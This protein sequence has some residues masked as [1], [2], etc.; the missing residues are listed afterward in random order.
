MDLKRLFL[1]GV[2]LFAYAFTFL[3]ALA[4]TFVL[5]PVVKNFAIRIG[6][7]DKPDARKVH[8][9]LVPRLG[10]LAIYAGFMVSAITTIGFTY[11]MVGIMAGATF[12]IIVG[13]ADDV[14]S[15]RPKVKLLGQIIAAAIPVVIFNINIDWINVPW[16]GIVYLPAVISIPL[17]IFWIIGFINTVNL[18]DGLDGLAAGIATIASIAIALL[19]FQMGQWTAAAAMVA[20]TGACLAFLQYNFNPAKIFMG[21]TGSMFLGYIIAAVSVMGSMKTAAAAVLIVPLVALAVPITDTLLA[22]VRRKSSGVPIF[23]PD[24]NHLHH[25]LLAKGLNQKQVVLIM[26]ALTAFFSCIA[27]VVIHLSL[28]AGIAIV[29]AA[30]ILFILWARKLGVMKEIV[31]SPYQ[32]KMKKEKEEK[33]KESKSKGPEEKPALK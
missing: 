20:M 7:V 22:I 14:V 33:G 16:H 15:L 21:D 10:G 17:T 3:V 18:I 2:T 1:G 31:P 27:L 32:M 23:S 29:A 5:T 30:L 6:A 11:E 13:V 19:A 12:L 28:W 26:Y 4:V 25:R 8:H 9:G 24:K